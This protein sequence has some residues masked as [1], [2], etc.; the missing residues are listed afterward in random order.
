MKRGKRRG[1][2]QSV[3]PLKPR[4]RAPKAEYNP[5]TLPRYARPLAPAPNQ[6]PFPRQPLS[7]FQTRPIPCLRL[8]RFCPICEFRA[9]KVDVSLRR[10]RGYRHIFP[11][12]PLCPQ[13]CRRERRAST[14]LSCRFKREKTPRPEGTLCKNGIFPVLSFQPPTVVIFLTS[15]PSIAAATTQTQL[16]T[17]PGKPLPKAHYVHLEETDPKVP[18]KYCQG[19][20]DVYPSIPKLPTTRKPRARKQKA[21]QLLGNGPLMPPGNRRGYCRRSFMRATYSGERHHRS[22]EHPGC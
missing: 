8:N 6:P 20:D 18:C 14:M 17:G 4:P 22:G 19:P 21:W 9:R 11:S 13:C 2:T 12:I 5:C 10:F 1:A 16:A 3:R 15:R 7:R